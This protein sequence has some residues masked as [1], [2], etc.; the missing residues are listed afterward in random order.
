MRLDYAWLNDEQRRT[1]LSLGAI[2]STY[3]PIEAGHMSYRRFTVETTYGPLFVKAYD[4]GL[5]SDSIRSEDAKRHLEKEAATY[6]FLGSQG[7]SNIPEFHEFRGDMLLLSDLPAN[8]GWYWE[9]PSDIANRRKYV[10][11]ALETAGNIASLAPPLN[12]LEPR[13]SMLIFH[14]D[15]WSNIPYK[16]A[17]SLLK[18][19]L[20]KWQHLLHTETADVARKL[21]GGSESMRTVALNGE[22]M[23]H[24][25][26]RQANVAW[27]PEHGIKIVD[28]SWADSGVPGGDTTMMMIDLKKSGF[29]IPDNL[30]AQFNPEFAA[31]LFGYWLQRSNEPHREGN[32]MV[33]FH[34]FISALIAY[35]LLHR[36]G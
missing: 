16:T 27:H 22:V 17:D 19:G 23:S 18:S 28:W 11:D 31:L 34:Q 32:E 26:L 2:L 8:K 12:N 6:D 20:T 4:A 24:H 5:F 13:R 36:F 30:H 7:F 1:L 21:L 14:E 3:T 33:R 9:L 15:G 10:R 29:E 25:D 35:Q